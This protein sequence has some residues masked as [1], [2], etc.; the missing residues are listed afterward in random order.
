MVFSLAESFSALLISWMEL[1]GVHI[2]EVLGQTKRATARTRQLALPILQ[3]LTAT[4]YKTVIFIVYRRVFDH[5]L[6]SWHW[7]PAEENSMHFA[8][9]S[10]YSAALPPSLTRSL[11][12]LCLFWIDPPCRPRHCHADNYDS[13]LFTALTTHCE[14]QWPRVNFWRNPC[15]ICL[16][17]LVSGVA[18]TCRR[19]PF[20]ARRTIRVFLEFIKKI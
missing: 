19:I 10:C 3:Q 18:S 13:G 5:I 4:R 17:G 11:H 9:C 8:E 20:S 12:W 1:Q 7:G 16:H 2:C 15:L 14:C 6:H